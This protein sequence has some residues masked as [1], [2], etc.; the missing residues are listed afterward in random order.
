[1]GKT[2]GRARP[3]IGVTGHTLDS[4]SGARSVAAGE[5]YLAA[6]R[7]AGGIPLILPPTGDADLILEWLERVDGV[8]FTG[9]RDIDP[10]CYGET[11]LNDTVQ[12]EP[13]RDA[14]ELPLARQAVSR[15]VPI[16]AICRGVQVLNVALG[17]TLWQDLPAQRANVLAH[18]Q[19]EPRD[20]TTHT[21]QVV[22]GSLL[23]RT[24]AS[25]AGE[26]EAAEAAD[27]TEP[28]EIAETA[29]NTF[30]HQAV[31]A[32]APGLIPTAFAA[33]GTVEALEAPG[34]QFVLGVQWHPENLAPAR[35]A[36]RRLFEAFVAAA[37]RRRP[38]DASSRVA[39]AALPVRS[40]QNTHQHDYYT[41]RVRSR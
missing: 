31:R 14:F 16:L 32:I 39:V 23:A 21:V 27:V 30:H 8:L 11:A 29:T 7:A 10:A 34:K 19:T 41:T 38:L 40:G 36:H 13:E 9:G 2:Y 1:M 33:D 18:R 35:P 26:A 4:A 3:A 17:G 37:E 12:P 25:G 22:A 28:A 6:V 20:A 24:L 5:A 15:D